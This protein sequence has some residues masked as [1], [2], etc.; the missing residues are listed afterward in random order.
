[1]KEERGEMVRK[2]LVGLGIAIATFLTIAPAGANSLVSSAP[3][4]GSTINTS[5]G[6]LT[7]TTAVAVLDVGNSVSVTDP[8]GARVDDGTITVN[9]SD[10]IA[11]L[12]TLT[13]DG[14][15]TV[16]YTLLS[17]NDV[18]LQGNFT[19]IFKAPSVINS[20]T[21]T[22][23]VS[24]TIPPETVNGG[25]GV[26]ALIVALIVAAFLVFVGLCLYAWNIFK[27]R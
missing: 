26:P 16:S 25:G 6:A 13:V 10:V 4:A 14:P 5:P 1:M 11:G 12:K 27:K 7:L 21:P 3:S 19:F 24:S 8:Q 18:P 15:Y 9:G 17:D 20:A 22:S 23:T 2:V